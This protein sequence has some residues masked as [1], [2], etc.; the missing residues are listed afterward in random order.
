MYTVRNT[1]DVINTEEQILNKYQDLDTN[2]YR[3]RKRNNNNEVVLA[4]KV[5]R[6]DGYNQMFVQV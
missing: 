1:E 2:K 3:K 4:D 6:L 5:M